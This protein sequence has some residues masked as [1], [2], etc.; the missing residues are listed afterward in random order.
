MD[1]DYAHYMLTEASSSQSREA[2]RKQLAE[3]L[4]VNWTRILALKNKSATPTETIP[5]EFASYVH[6][7]K[8]SKTRRHIPQ[9]SERTLDAPDIVDDYHLNLMWSLLATSQDVSP[10]DSQGLAHHI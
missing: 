9:T 5:N 10:E 6:Q 2:Y 1:F 7:A 4:N 3:A 8:P